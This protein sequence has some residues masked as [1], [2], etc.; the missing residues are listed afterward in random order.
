[1]TLM[2][3]FLLGS[4]VV[5]TTL[6]GCGELPRPFEGVHDNAQDMRLMPVDKA[7][8]VVHP[9]E[10]MP[11]AA[12][13]ALTRALID[14]L[15]SEDVAAMTPPGNAA[16][17]VLGGTATAE[18]AGWSIHLALADANKTSLGSITSHA[19][20]TVVDDPTAWSPFAK[21][22]AKSIAALLQTDG[23][24]PRTDQPNVVIGDVRGLP[25]GE[26]R[27]M[28]HALEFALQR[29]RVQVSSTPDK[30][31]HVIS[32][33]IL[34]SPPHGS[35][36]R[37]QSSVDVKWTVARADKSEVGQLHQ[38]NDVP[39]DMLSHDWPDIAMAVADAAVDGIVD[40]VNR[41]G[42]TATR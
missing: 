41:R 20:P 42:D 10:G 25:E 13:D 32:G 30:A 19:A 21:A 18:P 5:L 36:G 24:T 35:G 39:V 31:T 28:V 11:G 40:L 6:A 34:I 4:F 1:M 14:A 27:M 8:M 15:R 29:A 33:D 16:S 17:L 22:M 23:T 2:R 9:P 7:G 37:Q 38:A 12:A 26:R 3:L